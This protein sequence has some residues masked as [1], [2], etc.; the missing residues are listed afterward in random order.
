MADWRSFG[1]S[2]IGPGHISTGK[3]NQD[4]WLAFHHSWGD[5]VVVSDGLGSKPLSEFGS[6]MACRAVK[7]AARTLSKADADE[8]Q[9]S[10][11]DR[12]QFLEA[13]H[14]NWLE[15]IA[16]LPPRDAAATCLFVFSMNDGRV[17]IGMLG[18]GCIAVIKHNGDVSSLTDDKSG[19]FS[20]M[21][22]ALSESV[23]E[24][25]WQL[26]SIAEDDCSAIML[27]T[28][29]VSD[30]LEDIEGFAKSFKDAYCGLSR[31]LA[32]RSARRML[33]DWPT[34]KHSDD[35]TIA[36][37]FKKEADAEE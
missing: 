9:L 30:D 32:S 2:I 10:G 18:D 23:E 1:A 37:L 35:K 25:H 33:E 7:K 20:N 34:P 19:S 4:A 21:T 24:K 29:G 17:W 31:I 11:R 8:R 13:I 3:P 16:P 36:C 12:S 22:S 14:S 5:G 6:Q 27:C 26:S 28:D 15:L